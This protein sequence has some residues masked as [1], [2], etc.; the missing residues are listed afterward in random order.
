M[1]EL[2]RQQ[3]QI[4]HFTRT[5]WV[6]VEQSMGQQTVPE[7]ILRAAIEAAQREGDKR[8]KARDQARAR[9]IANN[10]R[11]FGP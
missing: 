9:I 6:P 3:I 4:D 1:N 5:Y 2:E 8:W 10:R 7:A 11:R